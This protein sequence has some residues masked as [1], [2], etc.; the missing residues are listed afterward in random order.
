MWVS[1]LFQCSKLFLW[2]IIVTKTCV[3]LHEVVS[4]AELNLPVNV[5]YSGHSSNVWTCMRCCV[6]KHNLLFVYY[7]YF[8]WFIMNSFSYITVNEELYVNGEISL[9]LQNNCPPI[10]SVHNTFSTHYSFPEGLMRSSRYHHLYLEIIAYL[11]LSLK[12]I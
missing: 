8:V 5:G 9:Q 1:L 2:F 7:Y 11:Q 10:H 3:I 6:W 4:E 12:F